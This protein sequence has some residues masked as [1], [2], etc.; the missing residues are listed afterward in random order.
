MQHFALG[1]LTGLLVWL[2]VFII[3][4]VKGWGFAHGTGRYVLNAILWGAI[5][6][7]A[8]LAVDIDFPIHQWLGVPYRFWH[9]P[10]LILGA[11][12]AVASFVYLWRAAPYGR[13]TR[14]GFL[15]LVVGL[16]FLTHVLEDYLLD[17]F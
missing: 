5:G 7:V 17:W 1:F 6:G 4:R 12:L 13:R 14:A 15:V 11:I 10:A 16:S 8:N 3:Y 9:T 2:S